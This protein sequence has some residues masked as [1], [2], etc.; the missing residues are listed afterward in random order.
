MQPPYVQNAQLQRRK[1]LPCGLVQT[2]TG[3]GQFH[4]IWS[5]M[6][7]GHT[8]MSLQQ[9]DLSAYGPVGDIQYIRRPGETGLSRRL[10]KGLQGAKVSEVLH[11]VRNTNRRLE[12]TR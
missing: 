3:F 5:A 10:V 7:Q 12:K 2:F 11:H 1:G 8:Q 6:E 9:F 4:T